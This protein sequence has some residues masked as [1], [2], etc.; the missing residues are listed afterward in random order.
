MSGKRHAHSH[1]ASRGKP[2]IIDGDG[3]W[4]EV[5]RCVCGFVCR[6]RIRED[7][8]KIADSGWAKP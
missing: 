6:I 5:H 2:E 3:E 8:E 7:G 4:T 1:D